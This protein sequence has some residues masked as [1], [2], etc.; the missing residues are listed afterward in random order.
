MNFVHTPNVLQA[1]QPLPEGF[2]VE[3]FR[4][5]R[6]LARGGFSFVYLATSEAHGPVALKEYLPA[7]L[8]LRTGADPWPSVDDGNQSAFRHGLRC[9]FEEGRA[10]ADLRHPNVVRVLDF[11]RANG[12]AYL[13]MRYERGRSLQERIAA[14]GGGMSEE[15]IRDT[16]GSLLKGLREVHSTMR[17]H[18]DIK[19]GNIFVR[20][21]GM[22]VLV[23]FGAARNAL[24]SDCAALDRI[25]TPGFA[26][27]EQDVKHAP[28]GPWTDIYSV[29]ASMYACI[30]ATPPPPPAE[31]GQKDDMTAARGAWAAKYSPELLDIIE[32]CLRLDPEERPPSVLALQ[33]ALRGE[34]APCTTSA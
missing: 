4:I 33:K 30:A 3:G 10:L 11:F 23:D 16:F 19:P 2:R 5:E 18:L 21:D 1:N 15:W 27:P 6:V 14:G 32:W 7:W 17:L 9:F 13:A 25:F 31:R 28:L 24:S 22:P 34:V 12:T 29:G 8:A 20:D 26:A